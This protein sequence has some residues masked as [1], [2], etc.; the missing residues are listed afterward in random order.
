MKWIWTYATSIFLIPGHAQEM[1][2]ALQDG[3]RFREVG[4]SEWRAAEVPGV[5]HT[6][7]MRHGL[8][9]DPYHGNAIDSVQWVEERDWEYA[10]T[11][12][13]DSS[14]LQREH[15]EL[16]FRGLDTFA[17][18][19][20]N[21]S[22]LGQA[23]NMFRTWTWPI[24]RR[25]RPGEN[26][27]T[28][29]FRSVT[30]QGAERRAAFGFQLPHDSDPSGVSPYVRKAAYQFGWDFCPRMVTSGIWQDVVLRVW[31]EARIEAISVVQDHSEGSVFLNIRSD[32]V[33]CLP[34]DA[35]IR[36]VVGDQ[37]YEER[38]PTADPCPAEWVAGIRLQGPELWWPNGQG[39]QH[40]ILVRVELIGDHGAISR[41]EARIGLRSIQLDQREDSVGQAF[42]FVVNGEPTFMKGCNLVP[43]HLLLPLAGDSAWVALVREMRR[44][45]MN[46]V[47]IWAGGVYPP[48]AFF[49]ACDMAGILVW[50]DLMF[51]SIPGADSAFTSNVRG[52]IKDQVRRIALHPSLALWCGNNE[53]HV[54]W[55]NWGWQDRYG[56]HGTDSTRIEK[57]M[58]DFFEGELPKC[59]AGYDARTP[60]TPTSALSN[61][62]N[63]RGLRYGDL[64]YWGV[65]HAD[66]TFVSF[67]NNVGRFMSEYGFQSYPDSITL[68]E[69]F[70][71]E[72]LYPGSP[73]LAGMQR[74]Y[75]T[76]R[77]IRDAIQREL[78]ISPNT[79]GEFVQASQVVQARAYE[80]A[81]LAHR[82]ARPHCMGTLLWQLNDCWP[83]PSWSIIDFEG[84]RKRAYHVVQKGFEAD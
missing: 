84:R 54:A 18:V 37:V 12:F 38:V 81:I 77:P 4:T 69:H 51:A 1:E 50:Q 78:G 66:S 31:D 5:V 21:D 62:G 27:L 61:W 83:G 55:R 82:N 65:W 33:G 32:L 19:R 75:R 29:I 24:E 15:V 80:A 56:I 58:T 73:T 25:L 17:E 76:D 22:L 47:R 6:D 57:M 3:W 20:L 45:H 48:E 23:D 13:A 40:T 60:Y 14:I 71:P 42:T 10:C 63:E 8:I 72:E 16:V 53:L 52:E 7:L 30:K 44:A 2:L 46:M 68:A 35:R 79:L 39:E 36:I 67:T 49:D 74:S 70:H 64:H 34:R 9:A 11:L 59:I 28:V 26:R 43:P 41:K